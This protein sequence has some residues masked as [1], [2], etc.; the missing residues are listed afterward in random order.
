MSNGARMLIKMMKNPLRFQ[1]ASL[2]ITAKVLLESAKGRA[3]SS[4]LPLL[5]RLTQ[6][7]TT[8]NQPIIWS[9][10]IFARFWRPLIRWWPLII[11]CTLAC[12]VASTACVIAKKYFLLPVTLLVC[13]DSL[14]KA[15]YAAG[16]H[17]S[18]AFFGIALRFQNR[19]APYLFCKYVDS[20]AR[21]R[22]HIILIQTPHSM[23]SDFR[24]AIQSRTEH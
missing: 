23:N 9:C 10:R 4:N 14:S 20:L 7:P 6:H 1:R 21:Y 8:N 12:A 17:K 22:S 13:L 18:I 15:Q 2:F 16:R 3:K 11:P 5:P 24:L 19:P